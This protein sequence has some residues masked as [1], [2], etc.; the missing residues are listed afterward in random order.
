MSYKTLIFD[1]DGT[2]VHTAP[3]YRYQ[4]VGETLKKLGTKD[5]STDHIDQF[6]FEMDRDRIIKKY[7]GQEPEIFWKVYTEYENV[8]LRRQFIKLYHDVDFV[9]HLKDTGYKIGVV[10]GSPHHITDLEIGM[11]GKDKFDSVVVARHS[12]ED[13]PLEGP[14]PNPWGIEKCLSALGGK[15]EESLYVGNAEEDVLAARNAGILDVYVERGEYKFDLDSLK[16]S[17]LIN[18]LYDLKGLLNIV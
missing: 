11:I 10:T 5:Y 3:E 13:S 17:V 8:Q 16:P 18:S 12:K 7:F 14:K 1:L 6:W 9:H 15:K 4:I 2:L